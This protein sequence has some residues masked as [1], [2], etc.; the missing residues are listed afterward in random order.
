[1]CTNKAKSAVGIYISPAKQSSAYVNA[2]PGA[3]QSEPPSDSFDSPTQ[4]EVFGPRQVKLIWKKS[5][6]HSTE[7]VSLNHVYFLRS[8]WSWKGQT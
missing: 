2:K 3:I 1:M 4:G 8:V 7:T 5:L 6:L